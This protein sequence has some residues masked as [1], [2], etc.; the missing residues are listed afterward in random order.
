MCITFGA[1]ELSNTKLYAG[2]AR[3]GDR[4]VHVVAYQNKV[5]TEGPNAMVLPLPA[6]VMP[7]PENVVDTRGFQRFLDDIHDAT[8]EVCRG[9]EAEL[10]ASLEAQVFDVGSYTV[11]LAASP[12]A[13]P[14]A[15]AGVPANKRPAVNDRVLGAFDDLYPGWPLA[16]CCWDGSFEAEPLLWW[17]EPR[18]PDQLF[19]PS[20]DAHD[21]Q[22]PRADAMVQVDHHVAFGSTLRP[23]GMVVHYRDDQHVR[24]QRPVAS[25][26]LLPPRVRGTRLEG[27][28]PNSDFWLSTKTALA[29]PATRRAPGAASGVSVPLDGWVR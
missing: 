12:L 6:A 23:M 24:H 25:T 21:G 1:A 27:A 29:G 4:Y 9:M 22:P 18:M 2:E 10:T 3:R 5:A 7:G 8:G 15:L 16:V 11:V 28:M 14:G 19:A 13:V 20:L 17:Y 26:R